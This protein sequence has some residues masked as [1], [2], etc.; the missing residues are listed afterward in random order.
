[1]SDKPLA[2][3]A[4]EAQALWHAARDAGVVHAVTFNYRGNPLV[5]QARQMIA[6]GD[7]GPL[8]YVHGAYL[9]DWLLE[10]D[11]FL[12]AAR[13]RQGRPELGDWRHRIA[14]VRSG[15]ARDRPADPFGALAT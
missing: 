7:I 9:Q 2:T 10:A 15:R 4:A 5:Q 12:L 8:H 13:A 1:M 3:S 6:A 11:R 14:L